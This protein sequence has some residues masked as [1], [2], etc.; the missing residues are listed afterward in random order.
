[1]GALYQLLR[2]HLYAGEIEHKGAVYPGQHEA[3]LDRELWEQV[4]RLLD[5]NRQGTRRRPRGS[6]GSILTGLLF[7]ESGARYIP[8]SAHKSGRRYHYY[9][10]QARIKGEKN[11]GSTERLPG[12]ALEAAVTERIL[13]FL[14]SPTEVLDSVK[15]LEASDMNCDRI[16]KNARQRALDWPSLAQAEKAD[17][18]RALLDRVVVHGDSIELQLDINS[19]V[20]LLLE[21]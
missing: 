3:A 20:H 6:S 12:P 15:R 7:G 5:E 1:R 14:H 13:N 19:I 4:Q 9:T 18:I 8:T 10:S 21:K 11:D 17:L 2:N 16:L